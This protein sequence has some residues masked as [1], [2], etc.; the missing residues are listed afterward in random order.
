MRTRSARAK[1]YR[2]SAVRRSSRSRSCPMRARF[3]TLNYQLVSEPDTVNIAQ[4]FTTGGNPSGYSLSGLRFGIRIDTDIDALSWALY[5]DNAGEPAAAPLFTEIAVPSESLDRDNKTFEDLVH[6]G[7]PLA[8]DTKYWAVL[9]AS[10]LMEGGDDADRGRR[11][12]L[13][14][15]RPR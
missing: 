10:P 3:P 7:F 15:Q 11:G 4:A 2:A 6:P 1:R 5:D 14:S 12:D 8:P 9:T 13:R